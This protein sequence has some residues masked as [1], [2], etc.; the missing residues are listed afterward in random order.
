MAQLARIE[1][2][3]DLVQETVDRGAASVERI[4]QVIAGLPFDVLEALGVPDSLRLR[5]RQRRVIGVVYGAVRD[6]NRH[7]GELLS[8]GF[9]AVEDGRHVVR[10]LGDADS[11]SEAAR[12]RSR[13]RS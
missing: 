8:D 3:K 10:V 6:A 11:V 2:V 1:L 13:S 9:E 7:L 12:G 5:D 4:H